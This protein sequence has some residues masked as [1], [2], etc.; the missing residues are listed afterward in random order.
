MPEEKGAEVREMVWKMSRI[1]NRIL[2]LAILL[3]LALIAI[4]RY[5]G[6]E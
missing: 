1:T 2:V 3:I 6:A 5:Y 4:L